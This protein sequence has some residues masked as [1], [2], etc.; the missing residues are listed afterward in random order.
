MLKPR[1]PQKGVALVTGAARRIGM[2]V[3]VRLAEAGFDLALHASEGARS[4]AVSLADR[5]LQ[6]GGKVCVITGD[7]SDAS[8]CATLV[9]EAVERL[10]PLRL[11]VNNAAIFQA[12]DASHIDIG[13]WERH[14]AIN[15][16][17]PV[18][19]SSAF[20]AQVPAGSFPV[21]S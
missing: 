18:L 11:L 16:R 17:A 4:E 10:G 8:R 9:P 13:L 6:F 20:A 21:R 12:D 2:A 1:G 15:L 3:A 5:L 14:F 19:L 7:L